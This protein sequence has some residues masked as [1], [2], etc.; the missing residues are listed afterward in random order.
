M[1]WKRLRVIVEVAVMERGVPFTAKD[2]AWAVRRA[3]DHDAFW[4]DRKYLP[5]DKQ[6]IFGRV[7]VKQFNMVM[8]REKLDANRPTA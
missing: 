2:L 5:K 4:Q 3:M 8:A 7:E 6:P 1:A